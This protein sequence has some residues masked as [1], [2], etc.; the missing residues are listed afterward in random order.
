M[1]TPIDPLAPV[2]AQL[3]SMINRPGAQDDG[4]W[5]NLFAAL[6]PPVDAS[7][8]IS[9]LAQ[10]K[11]LSATGRNMALADPESA[12][13]MMSIINQVEVN[14]KAQHEELEQMKS[15]VARLQ[16]AGKTLA[17]GGGHI[18]L[19]VLGF[20]GQYNNWIQRFSP[21]LQPGGVLCG[22]QAAEISRYELE[23]SVK[24][25]FFGAAE[26]MYGMASLGVTIDPATHLA[27][28]DSAKLD[29]QL[30][31]DG[32]LTT[33]KEFGSHFAESARLLISE[34]NFIP[35]Q[36][37]NLERGIQY[38]RDNKAALQQE[39]GTGDAPHPKNISGS[40]GGS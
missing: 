17:G 29:A 18:K 8:A 2:K 1:T 20:V 14:S 26:G 5:N 6:L 36:L 12:Y 31:N 7:R 34:G 24:S 22:T 33:L 11:G 37:D 40:Q 19:K 16:E 28:L 21:D 35:R 30:Q 4:M 3:A 38:I 9:Q 27:V 23:Q 25:R 15:A 32:A 13:K 39:F 10:V